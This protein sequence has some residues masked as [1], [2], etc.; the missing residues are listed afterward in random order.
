M[1][2]APT[3]L[4]VVHAEVKKPAALGRGN[5]LIEGLISGAAQQKIELGKGDGDGSQL[6]FE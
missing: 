6:P 5:L 1:T 2:H 4:R 3:P